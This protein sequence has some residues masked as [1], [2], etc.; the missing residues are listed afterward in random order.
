VFGVL[1]EAGA[2]GRIVAELVAE[3]PQGT[4][5]IGEAAGDLG[6]RE[7][8]DEVSP[9]GFVLAVEGIFRG[10]EEAGSGIEG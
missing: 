6:A 1:K 5:G 4:G 9:E 7:L 2:F 10:E 3:D 8:L